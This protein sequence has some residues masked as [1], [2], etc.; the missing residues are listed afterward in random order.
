MYTLVSNRLFLPIRQDSELAPL[1]GALGVK[2]T[3]AELKVVAASVDA[4]GSGDISFSEF[5]AWF[6]GE[7]CHG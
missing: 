6:A 4:D 1:L 7:P 5:Y 3:D 2:M